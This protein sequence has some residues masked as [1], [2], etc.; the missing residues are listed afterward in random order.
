MLYECIFVAKNACARLQR[1]VLYL[2]F[3]YFFMW[4]VHSWISVSVLARVRLHFPDFTLKPAVAGVPVCGKGPSVHYCGNKECIDTTKEAGQVL[5]ARPRIVPDSSICLHEKQ[6]R[7]WPL[8]VIRANPWKSDFLPRTRTL[9]PTQVPVHPTPFWFSAIQ[10]VVA[11]IG[12][13]AS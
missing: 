4:D 3:I 9:S 13:T 11:V 12:S 10:K 7:C 2:Y 8:T 1:T 5:V 6:Q